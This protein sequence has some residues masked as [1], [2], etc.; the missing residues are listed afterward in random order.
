MGAPADKESKLQDTRAAWGFLRRPGV[1]A[2]IRVPKAGRQ[3]TISGYTDDPETMARLALEVDRKGPGVYWTLNPVCP[4]LKARASDRV[5]PWAHSTTADDDVLLLESLLF[6]IDAVRPAGISATDA[7]HQAALELARRI[8]DELLSDGWP[9]PLVQDSGN[10]AYLIFGLPS[11][12]NDDRSRELIKACLAAA[13]RRFNTG[14]AVIDESTFN[15]SR[16]VKVPGT[17]ACKGDN[18]A[19][20]PHRLSRLLD[21]PDVRQPVSL[22]LLEG[23]AATAPVVVP[24]PRTSARH[25]GPS[26]FNLDRWI[27][28]VGLRVKGE[29]VGKTGGRKLLL[30]GCPFQPDDDGGNPFVEQLPGDGAYVFKCF[31]GDCS[32]KDWKA[33]RRHFDSSYRDL[34]AGSDGCV[35]G[36]PVKRG[37]LPRICCNGRQLRDKSAD[38]IA[39]L[40]AANDPPMLFARAG[41]LAVIVCYKD[42]RHAIVDLKEDS[43]RGV[44]ARVA[45]WFVAFKAKAGERTETSC[46]PPLDVVKDL[47]SLPP[48]HWPFPALDGMVEMPVLRPDGT[49]LNKPG[50][51]LATRL[52]FAPD[53]TLQL[54]EIPTAPS[55]SQVKA[56]LSLIVDEVL[57]DIPFVDQPSRANAIAGML[58]VVVK[59]AIN[60]PTPAELNDAPQAG[61]GKSLVAETTAIITT[62]RP[63]E[64][65][66][67]P[68]EEEEVRKHICTAL[69]SG[70]RIIVFDNVT[71]RV[72]SAEL[73]K[74]I[75]ATLFADRE[76]RTHDKILLPVN[77]AFVLTGNNLAVSGDMP[78]RCYWVRMDAK[79]SKPFMRTG[80]RHPN[81]KA[82][83]TEH[84]GALLAALLTLARAWFVAGRPAPKL[85][86]LGGFEA[87]TLMVGGILEHAGVDGFL[88]NASALYDEID[89]DSSEWEGFLLA[90]HEC[91]AAKPFTVAEIAE[92]LHD[93][94]CGERES[95]RAALPGF[96]AEV[97][98]R[99]G[100]FQRR[101]GKCFAERA[102]R[103]FGDTQVH[104]K[105]GV[106]SHGR[107]QWVTVRPENGGVN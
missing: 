67:L 75:T 17:T 68:R 100:F 18:T 48:S 26:S 30:E 73:C 60:A 84:R 77:A 52:F 28:S 96:L 93:K 10:G 76:F 88:G 92:R 86:P 34:P 57:G 47:L 23:L 81:L 72:N 31:H 20:R 3:K 45:D 78:R 101:A 55:S 38:A 71:Q 98:D 42:G 97:M 2:E 22:E 44:L 74:A 14:S 50:Y 104:L 53:P 39:A 61:T 36:Q 58:T 54:P 5:K 80:F 51:D 32:N 43:M 35:V 11:L 25:S 95:L 4:E 87:W 46:A 21:V 37:E 24:K 69:R 103:R 94:F 33:L 8:R 13:A 99:E 19:T 106:L 63:A 79:Q 85:T 107:Q 105:R 56:A 16:I 49:I 90:I 59:S 6:D 1:V 70:A 27:A 82:W 66:S 102:G 64:M 65:F 91:F 62:G 29:R 41:N 40:K 89:S 15:A 9:E 7:E 12:P 83:V